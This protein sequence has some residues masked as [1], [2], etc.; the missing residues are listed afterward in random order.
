MLFGVFE[1]ISGFFASCYFTAQEKTKQSFPDTLFVELIAHV[2]RNIQI[3]FF[4]TEFGFNLSIL[5][6]CN[7]TE[8][9]N[10]DG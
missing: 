6:F 2:W 5:C 10:N 7:M 3:W 9:V 4:L 1:P 8:H